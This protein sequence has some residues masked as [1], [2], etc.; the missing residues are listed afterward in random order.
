MRARSLPIGRKSIDLSSGISAPYTLT[1]I[2]DCK[3]GSFQ[4]LEALPNNKFIGGGFGFLAIWDVG[5]KQLVHTLE[6]PGID[7]ECLCILPNGRFISAGGT[8]GDALNL[9]TIKVWDLETLAIVQEC[10]GHTSCVSSVLALPDGRIVSWSAKDGTIFIWDLDGLSYLIEPSKKLHSD[11]KP[12]AVIANGYLLMCGTDSDLAVVDPDTGKE[13]RHFTILADCAVAL[14]P[15]DWTNDVLLLDIIRLVKAYAQEFPI[16]S[17]LGDCVSAW[18]ALSE[19]AGEATSKNPRRS[20]KEFASYIALLPNGRFV[21]YGGWRSPVIYDQKTRSPMAKLE[22]HMGCSSCLAH[23]P[24]GRVAVGHFD[25]ISIW[26][27]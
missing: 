6:T 26:T 27:P 21:T 2:I 15:P 19:P 17:V 13:I 5:T 7:T 25:E 3:I 20:C 22:D 10:V 4:C 14:P 8:L 23:F 12:L 16:V 9:G 18:D 24:D 11:A 1:D